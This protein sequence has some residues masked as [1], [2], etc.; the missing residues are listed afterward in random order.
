MGCLLAAGLLTGT[1]S[2]RA[3]DIVKLQTEYMQ[4]PLGIDVARPHFGWQMQAEGYG[5]AQTAYQLLVATSEDA[6]R[7][8]D[9][10]YDSGRIE[11]GIATNIPYAGPAL[12]PASRYYWKVRV[13]DEKGQAHESQ[14]EWFE[15]GL[16]GTDWHQALWIGSPEVDLSRYRSRFTVEYDFELTKGSEEA[17]FVIGGKSE[18]QYVALSIHT[19]GSPTLRV[20][21]TQGGK[22]YEDFA[23]AL[24][25]GFAAAGKHH[26]K[27]DVTG[28][29]AYHLRIEV[30]G[31]GV[32]EADVYNDSPD[33]PN[34]NCRLYQIGYLQPK[35]QDVRYSGIRI[36]ENAWG[37]ELYSDGETHE[38]KGD[39]RVT[40]WQ[41]AAEVAAP[42][43]R[44]TV[45]IEKP[46][47][48][49]RLYA[50][51]RGVYEMYLNG[52]KVGEDYL[53]PGWTDF[54]KRIMYNTFDVTPLL[55]PGD[56]GLGAM[57]GTG[58]FTDQIGFVADWQDQYGVRPSLMA[59]LTVE[60]TDGTKEYIPTDGSWKCEDHGPILEN[61]LFHGEDYDARR[62]VEG[63]TE[64]TFDDTAWG[65]AAL[66][67]P[68]AESVI[69]QGYVGLPIRN[70]VTVR[71]Q[72]VKKIGDKEY[73]Y[74][75]GQNLAGIP[76]LSHLKGKAGQTLTLHFA[77]MLYPEVIPTEPVAPYTIE[78]YREKQGQLYRENYRS[79]LSTDRYTLSGKPEGETYSP[80]FTYHGFRY[81]SV[82][83]LDDPL[84]L[85]DVE[86]LVLESIGDQT[87]AFQTSSANV[88]RL[89]ENAVWGQR[90]NFLAVPTD[91]PQRDERCGWTGDAQVFARAATYNMPIDPFYTRWLY[92]VRDD[93][94]S[95]GAFG[96]YYPELGTPP[97]GASRYGG[98]TLGG[99][100]EAG[101]IVPWQMYQQYGDRGILQEHYAAMTAFIDYLERNATGYLQ[102]LGGT[103]D[104]LAPAYTN[105][106]LTNT[107][108]SAYA[109]KLMERIALAL[110]K[111][112]DATR[113]RTLFEHIKKA[114][115]E[116]FVNTD[117]RTVIPP[118]ARPVPD[119]WMQISV[120]TIQVEEQTD[121]QGNILVD[122]QTSYVLPLQFDLLDGTMKAKA[123]DHLLEAVHRNGYTL[124]TGF[125]GTP[126][127]CLVLS[128]NGHPEEAYKLFL[129]TEYPSW[130]FPVKQGATTFWER[131]NSYTLKN[132]FGPVSMNS[133]NHY[134]YGAIEEWMMSH[135]LGIQRDETTPG[136]KHF[137]LQPEPGEGLTYAKGGFES[138]YG[139]ITSGWERQGKK[140]VCRMTVP[141][142]TTATVTL[143]A[144]TVKVK[145]G[146]EGIY[147]QSQEE[148]RQRYE[149][150]SGEYEFEMDE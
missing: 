95:T 149:V 44:K 87:S 133:F 13:W 58:W 83:G 56:N 50:T 23:E 84:P 126:Y 15:T 91:C 14:A 48:S 110:E 30:D 49:A 73:I 71:A 7:Q 139:V 102:P 24:P 98:M 8:A 81:L 41:P 129:Q 69:L 20:S 42:M 28:P 92:T 88:N 135:C 82:E 116:T 25:T 96:G 6:L 80:R 51:A 1:T 114:F 52:E 101:I 113:F 55:H 118:S 148:D 46:V 54:G 86:A 104:W 66:I 109:A 35:G 21:H 16:L 57:L 85:E 67:A 63:W 136:Y 137:Y 120:P 26:V 89:F 39:G 143:P 40:L 115:N 34:A 93:Q 19:K 59:L 97:A 142:N 36:S 5:A 128:D 68:P 134:A 32:K 144:K 75:L 150:S 106:M 2:L 18:A 45:R 11:S 65:Q 122:T 112:D 53:N 132:G 22:R 124:T 47:R 76:R 123:V 77:E 107:A 70:H 125:L 64:G 72:S 79:A 74:D 43:L 119:G 108:Y 117:G 105:T 33:E 29:S 10:V 27:V 37:T 141:A 9:Y 60:Y 61:S 131:W 17:T 138:P 38:V 103:G 4:R 62:E 121:A 111:T 3:T 94:S 146:K 127:I 100:M 12:R 90:S 140:T 147:A 130:L 78:M 99:W 145:K 31:H